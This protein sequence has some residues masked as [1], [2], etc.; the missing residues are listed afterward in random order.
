MNR[1]NGAS[2]N[3]TTKIRSSLVIKLNL[4]MMGRLLSGFLAVNVLI[5]LMSFF[6]I[7]WK[8]EEGI[9]DIIE[10]IK[11]SPD[12]IESI[13]Y[14]KGKYKI[15]VGE[16]PGKGVKLPKD[17]QNRLPVEINDAKRSFKI[18]ET[19]KGM[20]LLDKV[21]S[22]KYIVGFPLDNSYYQIIYLLGSDLKLF[23]YLFSLTLIFELLILIGSIDKGSKAIRKTLQPIA[24]LAET[25]K[26]LNAEVSS[27][28]S[29]T[30]GTYIKDLAGVISNID[31]NRLDSHIS[32]DSSQDELK[33]L[34]SAINGMLNRINDSYQSQVRFVSDASHELRT[35]ISVIQGYVNLLDRWG[36]KDEKTLQESIDAIKSETENMKDLVEQLLFLARGD[37]ETIQLHKEVFDSC[38]TM[39]EI[40]RETQIIDNSHIFEVDIN[41]PAYI[42]ADKQLLKQAIRILVDNSIKFTPSGDKIILRIVKKDSNIHIVVQDTGIGIEP[43]ALP[44]I[45][46]RFYRSDESRARKTGGSGLGLSIAKWIIERHGAYFEILSRVDIGTRITIVFPEEVVKEVI[47]NETK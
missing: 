40:I 16:E 27:I 42:N 33:D 14:R 28:G 25:A 20:R 36:K 18:S 38:E 24:E 9:Q 1:K 44:H 21:Y 11:Q 31:A 32:I 47:I 30:N 8:S 12:N 4:G 37:N 35:P 2:T 10:I 34:A 41:R 5:I 46:D 22:I 45:F 3:I 7:L 17:I 19:H 26:S 43:E 6:V 13:Y 29:K 15:L 39:D 23:L